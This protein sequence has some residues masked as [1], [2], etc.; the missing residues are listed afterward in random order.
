MSYG[1]IVY[2][3]GGAE[4]LSKA[5]N[6]MAILFADFGEP[7]GYLTYPIAIMLLLFGLHVLIKAITKHDIIM[8]IKWMCWF[9]F[10]TIII[11]YP[12]TDIVVK[13]RIT[14]N[15]YAVDNVPYIVGKFASIF[16][17][18]E[19]F[20][21]ESLETLMQSPDKGSGG[22]LDSSL[23]YS[24]SGVSFGS[25]AIAQ[26]SSVRIYDTTLLEN[27][28]RFIT[29][30]IVPQALM[31]VQ[32]TIEELKTAGDIWNLVT[33]EAHNTIGFTYR[34]PK[35]ESE[36]GAESKTAMGVTCYEGGQKITA[37]LKK[38]AGKRLNF[39][40][41][42][43]GWY[44]ERYKK[45]LNASL[46]YM[47]LKTATQKFSDYA[48]DMI[49]QQ[50]VINAIEDS[51]KNYSETLGSP[52]SYAATRA[53]IQQ[54]AW[55]QVT[56]EL[57]ADM[58]VLVKIII[59]TLIYLSFILVA[60]LAFA[61]GGYDVLVKYMGIIIWVQLW[62]PVYSIFNF[63]ATV[64]GQYRSEVLLDGEISLTADN[65]LALAEMH[66]R[67]SAIACGM[68]IFVPVFSYMILKISA[69]AF[70]HIASGVLG[71]TQS[72]AGRMATAI[73]DGNISEGVVQHRVSSSDLV[74]AYKHDSNLS[75][76]SGG[77]LMQNRDGSE[78][79]SFMGSNTLG[80]RKDQQ[81]SR[82]EQDINLQK[83]I[84]DAVQQGIGREQLEI[85]RLSHG[86]S[87]SQ[88]SSVD[89][90]SK[91]LANMLRTAGQNQDW[92][93]DQTTDAGKAIQ[94]TIAFSKSLKENLGLTDS[95]AAEV[96]AGLGFNIPFV[97]KAGGSF[98]SKAEYQ[99][100][101]SKGKE[102]LESQN[103]TEHINKGLRNL[104]QVKFG[105]SMSET[106]QLADE[107]SA[108]FRKTDLIQ[109]EINKSK[110]SLEKWNLT[111][112]RIEQSGLAFNKDLR[113]EF[114]KWYGE[115]ITMVNHQGNIVPVGQNNAIKSIQQ[116]DQG[117]QI[118][119]GKFIDYKINTE[120]GKVAA[121]GQKIEFKNQYMQSEL[122]KTTPPAV[123]LTDEAKNQTFANQAA[124]DIDQKRFEAVNSKLMNKNNNENEN[125]KEVVTIT[126]MESLAKN[127]AVKKVKNEA[128]QDD[129]EIS[130]NMDDATEK[131]QLYKDKNSKEPIN[132]VTS[133]ENNKNQVTTNI[134]QQQDALA[135]EK[136]TLTDNVN[137]Q[138]NKSVI[139][140]AVAVPSQKAVG[141]VKSAVDYVKDNI[142]W[143]AD[144]KAALTNA[145]KSLEE[146]KQ[147][148]D[149]YLA[150]ASSKSGDFSNTMQTNMV[151]PNPE[152]P[153]K[154]QEINKDKQSQNTSKSNIG[155][156]KNQN[157]I[158]NIEQK[159]S[160]IENQ[161]QSV[162]NP[163]YSSDNKQD[164]GTEA[165]KAP[166]LSPDR[167]TNTQSTKQVTKVVQSGGGLEET[168]N[169]SSSSTK[170]DNSSSQSQPMKQMNVRKDK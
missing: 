22:H 161:L 147:A 156:E 145:S 122:N 108:S 12:K 141:G 46:T 80:I 41:R 138:E 86:Y 110:Q 66:G 88:S 126:S 139:G 164:V 10:A 115:N 60:F 104:S 153:M 37:H 3:Y 165:L 42:E 143:T 166:E 44:K 72:A 57:A 106:R 89:K 30:C 74:N 113:Q 6:I 11:F 169:K 31:G 144:A 109:D 24:N 140:R 84:S 75:H 134:E 135:Q 148:I 76:R 34:I 38:E 101:L 83:G 114:V 18:I 67:I 14:N 45:I 160:N 92:S 118:A 95:Q 27:M 28:D 129:L 71:G 62:S 159:Q 168:A 94:S 131:M 119:L 103:L 63:I 23:T 4:V 162:Q 125:K 167:S 16:S 130:G 33:S 136:A 59:E 93:I 102:L 97:G 51:S 151:V 149:Q 17:N 70:V 21:T 69:S 5:F 155:D 25:K 52:K 47:F 127:I 98:A 117:Y 56:G 79:F 96:S 48:L 81:L 61:P 111:K 163:V 36:A 35:G 26:I 152:I 1:D 29:Q 90:S 54:K 133:V 43:S 123:N 132:I 15:V 40:A 32:Y 91:A 58:M 49:K 105:Q 7:G 2:T 116:Q 146:A 124:Q 128:K 73:S 99:Q 154:P 121:P 53:M 120:I 65:V 150:P 137:K 8:P 77:S 157:R 13:D 82:W 50:L 19:K 170:Q 64:T 85:D 78:T 9:W 39:F 100:A 55:Y 142:P 68:S 87:Q 112:S 158:D 20:M 107:S